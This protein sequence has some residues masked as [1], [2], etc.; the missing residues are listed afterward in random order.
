MA[1]YAIYHIEEGRLIGVE[2]RMFSAGTG[3]FHAVSK[4]LESTENPEWL[5]GSVGAIG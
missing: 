3:A 2:T 1:R 4:E 5:S